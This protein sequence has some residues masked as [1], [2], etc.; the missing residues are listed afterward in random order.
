MTA[1]TSW[2]KSSDVLCFKI[3]GRYFFQFIEVEFAKESANTEFKKTTLWTLGKSVGN[4][5]EKVFLLYPLNGTGQPFRF[6]CSGDKIYGH[7]SGL[8]TNMHYFG[9][10]VM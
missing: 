7:Y 9:L 6:L 5:Y 2:V 10:L 1:N 8:S 3:A 4:G